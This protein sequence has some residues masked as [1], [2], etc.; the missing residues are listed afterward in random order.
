MNSLSLIF[1]L[2]Q[3]VTTE[4]LTVKPTSNRDRYRVIYTYINDQDDMTTGNPVECLSVRPSMQAK[5]WVNFDILIK[6]GT[7]V[8]WHRSLARLQ[9]ATK[10]KPIKIYN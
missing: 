9:N 6:L 3:H 7:C 10:R 8:P 2:L 1:I 5:N 4:F